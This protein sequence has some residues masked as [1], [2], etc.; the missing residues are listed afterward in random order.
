[1]LNPT[2]AMAP[3]P[4]PPLTAP[5]PAQA[6]NDD[7]QAF[8][9]ALDQAAAR[10]RDAAGEPNEPTVREGSGPRPD[11]PTRGRAGAVRS[12][13]DVAAEDPAAAPADPLFPRELADEAASQAEPDEPAQPAPDLAAWASN[14]PLP[15]PVAAVMAPAATKADAIGGAGRSKDATT[16]NGATRIARDIRATPQS[17]VE[18]SAAG[19]DTLLTADA[20]APAQAGQR[21]GLDAG[22]ALAVLPGPWA[23]APSRPVDNAMPAQAELKAPFG[24]NEFAPALGSQLSVMVR[25]GIDH[26][27]LKLNPAEMGPIEVRISIDGTLAQV[28]FSAA[29][30]VTRQ[31]LQDALP[32]LAGALRENGLTLTGGGVFEQTREHR[33]DTHPDG[34]RGQSGGRGGH[35]TEATALTASTARLPRARGVVDLYA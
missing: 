33:G 29:H 13:A 28:D 12:R 32:T 17:L 11:A 2:A 30:A 14:L 21:P 22:T 6:G 25:D 34:S 31:A 27:Q 3:S 9:Q 8:A 24:S 18:A 20:V 10:Q 19:K 1:M 15:R 23:H 7:S 4:T 35:A 16:A 5:G 26:A